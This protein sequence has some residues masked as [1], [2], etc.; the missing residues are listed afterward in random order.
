MKEISLQELREIQLN[1]LLEVHN[2]CEERNLRYSLG[3]GTLLGAVRHKGYI[4]WDDDIDIMMPRP[5]YERFIKE[6]VGYK[7][8]L[9]CGCFENDKNWQYPFAKVY[10]DNTILK[11]TSR[12]QVFGVNIDLF[13]IDGLPSKPEEL[14]KQIQILGRI[15]TLMNKKSR[16][17]MPHHSL[18]QLIGID[19]M[20]LIPNSLFHLYCKRICLAY[21]FEE[22]SIAGAVLGVYC[23]KEIYNKEVFLSY[24]KLQFERYQ[25]YSISD[26]DTYLKQHYGDYMKLPPK[27]K[28]VTHHNYKAW[29]KNER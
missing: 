29:Y 26:H 4:P 27:D 25:F 19:L 5:D 23:E 28:Q 24:E 13:P 7:K 11:E 14:K 8:N 1:I 17:K 20:K 21:D 10:D 16:P 22:T 12:K 15:M 18:K 2:F 9:I 6:F 3:G